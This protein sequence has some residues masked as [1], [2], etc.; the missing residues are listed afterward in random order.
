MIEDDIDQALADVAVEVQI[1]AADFP[2]AH[3]SHELYGILAGEMA[4][5]FDEVRKKPHMRGSL[6]MRGALAQIACV[7]IRGMAALDAETVKR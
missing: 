5:F 6:A 2:P 7:A 4:E 1:A 3:S